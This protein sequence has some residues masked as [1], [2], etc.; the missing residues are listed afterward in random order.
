MKATAHL[1]NEE[2]LCYRRLL[3]MYYDTEAPIPLDTERVSRRI[4]IPHDVVLVVLGDFFLKTESGWSN[5][6]CESDISVYKGFSEAGKR[7]A[8]KRWGKGADSPPIA[9]LSGTYKTPIATSNHEPVTINHKPSKQINTEVS[10]F[11]DAWRAYPKR[12]GANKTMARKAWDARVKA[13]VS[14]EL[15]LA[16]VNAYANYCAVSEIEPQY[17]KQA[18]TFF[19]AGEH[20]LSDWTPTHKANG[21]GKSRFDVLA[22]TAAKLTGRVT[23]RVID[24]FATTLD[25][26]SIPEVVGYLR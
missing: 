24:G 11:D 6:R 7:G 9:P 21:N 15:M 25:R 19:G 1:S 20:Y 12:P 2:D 10:L 4:R 14:Q 3:D 23:E 16:G 26:E 18:S 8:A 13:G 5:N 17:I 22:E